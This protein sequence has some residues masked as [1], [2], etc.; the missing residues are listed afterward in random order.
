MVYKNNGVYEGYWRDGSRH[1]HAS[2]LI[3]VIGEISMG[4]DGTCV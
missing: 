4:R 1:G 3:N 2:I